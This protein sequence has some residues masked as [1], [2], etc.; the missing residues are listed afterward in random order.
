MKYIKFA[1][2]A[3]ISA[4]FIGCGNDIPKCGD[5]EVQSALTDEIKKYTKKE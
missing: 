3:A 5:K 1:V 4:F 2:C